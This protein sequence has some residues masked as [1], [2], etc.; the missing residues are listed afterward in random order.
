M[1]A[2]TG[3]ADALTTMKDV[4][5]AHTLKDVNM[6]SNSLAELK[7]RLANVYSEANAF[8]TD[9][10]EAKVITEALPIG[11]WGVMGAYCGLTNQYQKIGVPDN[12]TEFSIGWTRGYVF[13]LGLGDAPDKIVGAMQ[14]L[15][16]ATQAEQ[17]RSL[18][19]LARLTED[20]K[21]SA[22]TVRQLS[23]QSK[24]ALEANKTSI[25]DLVTSTRDDIS[26]LLG[27]Y[28]ADVD[29]NR[30]RAN[31]EIS[32]H[33]KESKK[34]MDAFRGA[35]EAQMKLE[36]ASTFWKR[37]RKA[38]YARAALAIA[39]AI[40]AVWY[41]WP[42]F[43]VPLFEVAAE[44]H[45]LVAKDATIWQTTYPVDLAKLLLVTTLGLWLVRVCVRIFLSQTHMA[46]DAGFRV[47]LTNAY[48]SMLDKKHVEGDGSRELVLKS[49]FRPIAT[50][51]IKDDA[52]P[53]TPMTE[54]VQQVTK[55]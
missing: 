28:A 21:S 13:R 54:M 40:A 32:E 50:G 2:W 4:T 55:T 16:R 42:H 17:N 25:A 53:A 9:S 22:I 27:R 10:P 37:V 33:A 43:V 20:A 45:K 5:R 34:T 44:S 19:E 49:L 39:G 23:D 35:Y 11:A 36:A 29:L 31:D 3:L 41:G 1:R 30:N 52:M 46:L 8:N 24:A 47:V 51:M 7:D 6:L 18:A 26:K 12:E 48:V 14:T 38:C 15:L